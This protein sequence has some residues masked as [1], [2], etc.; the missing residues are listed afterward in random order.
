[1]RRLTLENPQSRFERFHVEY[2]E[3]A[4]DAALEVY[5]DASESILSENDSPHIRFGFSVNP[6]RGC[7]HGC[8]YCFARPSHE[9][10][11]FGAGT[12]F[13]RKLVVERRAPA[14][15]EQ[16]FERRS[17]RGELVVFSGNTDCYQPLE[18][19]LELTR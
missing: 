15:L 9:Y 2:E 8:A 16:A 12:D 4:P 3:G 1:M 6:Y 7:L 10:L 14:L 17:W 18:K 5:D 13:E 11:G 19:E